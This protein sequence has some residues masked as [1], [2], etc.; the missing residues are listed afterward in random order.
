MSETA[1]P[2]GE[3][4]IEAHDLVKTYT[5]GER[6]IEVLR[7]A[8]IHVRRGEALAVTGRS[9]AG[10]STL[11]HLL[12]LIDS[13]TGGAILLDGADVT[14][15]KAR[16]RALLRNRKFGFIFQSYHLVAELTALENVLLP[17]MMAGM[18]EWFG[19]RARSRKHAKA[20]LAEVGLA[21][22]LRHRPS[23]LSGGERQRVAI[24]RALVNE[25][26]VLFCDEPTGNLDEATSESIHSLLRRLNG[27]LGVTQVIV[28]HDKDLAS[29]ANRVVRLEG[30]RIV[31]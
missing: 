17:A 24:A 30:G 14:L 2:A 23:K 13:P 20:L 29:Q 6:T 9:G 27:E 3:K 11:L 26:E 12:G 31:A 4:V 5:D 8:D 16:E 21:E 25:P 10:K 28:T 19:V 18:L 7:G 15:A 22:R 1:K